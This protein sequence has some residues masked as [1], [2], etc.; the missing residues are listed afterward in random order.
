MSRA[1]ASGC[2]ARLQQGL[3]ELPGGWPV[4]VAR[5]DRP[6]DEAP[7]AVQEVEGGRRP[8]AVRLPGHVAALVKEHWCG[9]AP[10][11]DRALDDLRALP[12]VHQVD[13]EALGLEVVVQLVDGRQL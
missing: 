7:L 8:D 3:D 11:A 9:V 6:P 5:A 2:P 1:I 10:L 13:R 12:E 4:P